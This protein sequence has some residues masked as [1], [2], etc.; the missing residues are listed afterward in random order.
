MTF[1]SLPYRHT[2]REFKEVCALLIESASR[3][4]R[5]RNWRL[6]LAENWN[7]GSRY[8][9]P[10]TYF[11]ERVRLWRDEDQ[12]LTGALIRGKRLIHPQTLENDPALLDGLLGWAEEN[13]A[14]EKGEVSVLAFDWDVRRQ[15]VLRQR[16]YQPQRPVEEVRIYDLNRDYPAPTLPSGFQFSSVAEE[17]DPEARV[18]LENSIWDA[19]LDEAW[20]R[21]KSSAPHYDPRLDLLALSPTGEYAATAL[22]WVY[23][24]T[25]SA[26]IDPLGTHPAF[27]QLGLARAIALRSF[28]EMQKMG[29]TLAYIASDA[30]NDAANGLYAA[31]NPLERYQ[32][33]LWTKMLD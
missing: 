14:N 7:M 17:G 3:D 30:K 4:H 18:A 27:R 19:T 23:P 31:L 20:Y 25:G 2:Q 10:K 15:S 32:G 1:P 24:E 12:R 13:W 33:I 16:G 29:L 21:G 22:V 28:S 26:E 8:L 6:A 5:P 9:E 11:T